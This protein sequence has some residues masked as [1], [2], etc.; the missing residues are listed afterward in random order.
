MVLII[1]KMANLKKAF[2]YKSI[3]I[4]LIG[5]IIGYA[6]SSG[7]T[8]VTGFSDHS[9]SLPYKRSVVKG[10]QLAINNSN[11]TFGINTSSIS[12]HAGDNYKGS[13]ISD[14]MILFKTLQSILILIALIVFFS[15][16]NTGLKGSPFI[17]K[18]VSRLRCVAV[19]LICVSIINSI[20][21][22]IGSS[23]VEKYMIE[24]IF[25]PIT[26]PNGAKTVSHL[27]L[28]FKNIYFLLGLITL[29]ISEVFR[30]GIILKQE[31]AL[32]I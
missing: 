9:F 23:Y 31:Q 6:F 11:Y 16:V 7:Y 19:L 26:Y 1:K 24:S 32:T 12:I 29:L 25:A 17:H 14:Q 18:N 10:G 22:T 21:I 20:T 30:N 3:Q 5:G 8:L 13:S 2:L 15:F 4:I 27:S 28:P